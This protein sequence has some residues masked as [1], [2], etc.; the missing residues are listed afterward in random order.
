MPKAFGRD[1]LGATG[2]AGGVERIILSLEKQ[3]MTKIDSAPVVSVLF[4]NEEMIAPAV[5]IAS[6]LRQMG[7]ATDIDLVGRPFKKQIENASASKFSVIVAPKEYSSKQIVVK[8]MSDGKETIQ[9]IDSLLS[10]AKSI[11]SL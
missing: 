9:T 8:N 10:N 3:G 11:F 1:D 4:V 7:I 6:Q 2:V 5:N